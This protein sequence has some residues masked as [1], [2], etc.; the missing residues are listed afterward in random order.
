MKG[1]GKSSEKGGW[2]EERIWRK[3]KERG[4]SSGR[5]EKNQDGVEYEIHVKR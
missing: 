4:R 2:K 1:R 5:M 3:V